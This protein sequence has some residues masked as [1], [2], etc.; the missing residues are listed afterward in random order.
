MDLHW[1]EH[2]WC[3]CGGRTTRGT[4]N[5]YNTETRR[6]CRCGAPARVHTVLDDAYEYLHVAPTPAPAPEIT[7][8]ARGRHRYYLFSRKSPPMYKPAFA[9]PII[10]VRV[11]DRQLPPSGIPV[12]NVPAAAFPRVLDIQDIARIVRPTKAHIAYEW[13]AVTPHGSEILF[14]ETAAVL[15]DHR[16]R[17]VY[18]CGC[19]T[20]AERAAHAFD[21]P[22]AKLD[23]PRDPA[24]VVYACFALRFGGFENRRDHRGLAVAFRE[25]QKSGHEPLLADAVAMAKGIIARIK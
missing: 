14:T 17:V 11:V 13:E 4:G 6:R 23:L 21:Y 18:Q 7:V 5:L 1:T 16:D 3:R 22:I 24:A 20:Q 12:F 10:P 2:W 15:V 9:V 19:T 8:T 25:A